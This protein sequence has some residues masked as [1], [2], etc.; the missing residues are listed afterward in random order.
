MDHDQPE[1]Q[2]RKWK[3]LSQTRRA[4]ASAG[5]VGGHLHS[6]EDRRPQPSS[7]PNR[8]LL[9]PGNR[10]SRQKVQGGSLP[11]TQRRRSARSRPADPPACAATA[12]NRVAPQKLAKVNKSDLRRPKIAD[13]APRGILALLRVAAEGAR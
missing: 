10:P 3:L 6:R 8:L 13:T 9:T 12:S 5:P 4:T 11:V 2:K 7:I 1:A